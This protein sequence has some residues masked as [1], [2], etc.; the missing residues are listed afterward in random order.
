MTANSFT[1]LSLN[2]P[3]VLFCAGK[4]T[5]TGQIVHSAKG[6]SV[7]ILRHD[8]E[9]LSTYFA[10]GWKE[11]TPPPFRFVPWEGGPR[12][13]GSAA[14]MGCALHAVHEG[15]DH[16]IVVGRVLALHQGTEPRRPLVFFGGRYSI[17]E[18]SNPAP[19]LLATAGTPVLG[20]YDAWDPE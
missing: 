15:G 5:K 17:L 8:Q 10:G 7:N 4:T 6:F 19:D 2:P 9:A 13:E 12:L 1:S 3:L 18:K 20:Y 16:W 11:R 14:A